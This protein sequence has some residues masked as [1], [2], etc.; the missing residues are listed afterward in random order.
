MKTEGAAD[1]AADAGTS[2]IS[3][4]VTGTGQDA[5]VAKYDAAGKPLWV[6]RA[7]VS[8]ANVAGNDIA[9]DGATG[10]YV[11]GS[12]QGSPIFDTKTLSATGNAFV[13]RYDVNGAIQW[14]SANE[15]PSVSS[16]VAHGLWVGSPTSGVFVGGS[17]IETTTF[18]AKSL[19]STG[20]ED[21]FVTRLC[22]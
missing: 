8:N 15:S 5:F 6:K 17:F 12:K 18:G 22:N 2:A 4:A 20:N 21:G 11:V 16:G 10:V 9:F 19:T 13:A 14:V 3:L 1:I 7:G